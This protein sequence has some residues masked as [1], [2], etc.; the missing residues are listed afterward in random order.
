MSSINPFFRVA[1]QT[2]MI[3]IAGVMI[4]M[5]AMATPVLEVRINDTMVINDVTSVWMDVFLTNRTDSVAGF[6]IAIFTSTPDL[7]EFDTINGYPVIDTAGSLISGWGLVMTNTLGGSNQFMKIVA[8]ATHYPDPPVRAIA[9]H[10]ESGLLFRMKMKI[11]PFMP[12][13]L[14]YRND[15]L[16][17]NEMLS[18]T[19]FSDHDGNLIG[20]ATVVDTTYRYWHCIQWDGNVCLGWEQVSFPDEGDS[21]A[22]EIRPGV[23]FDSTLTQY[24]DGTLRIVPLCDGI[25][26]D[27]NG[28][29]QINVGDAVQMVNY[30]FKGG[31]LP[32]GDKCADPNNDYQIDIGDPVFLINHIFRGGPAPDCTPH[33]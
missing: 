25:C 24:H 15:D 6:S 11:Y 10:A 8:M 16:M 29:G 23:V 22:M 1:A 26:G 32:E 19:S 5:P 9:P 14:P 12:G 20:V 33:W 4:A 13:Y 17:I 18:M 27:A 30:I 31:F 2:A 7:A 3:F 21:I 28:D